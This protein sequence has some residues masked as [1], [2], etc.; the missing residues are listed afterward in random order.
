MPCVLPLFAAEYLMDAQQCFA[1]LKLSEL[2]PVETD[3]PVG[4]D[5]NLHCHAKRNMSRLTSF[6][7]DRFAE[8]IEGFVQAPPRGGLV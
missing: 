1:G 2:A 3:V 8:S 4:A 6:F 7:G 5:R